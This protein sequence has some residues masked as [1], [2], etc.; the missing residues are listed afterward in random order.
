MCRVT[1]IGDDV[2]DGTEHKMA[3]LL[4][5]SAG[6]CFLLSGRRRRRRRR[7]TIKRDWP[8][9]G[10]RAEEKQDDDD[11]HR[12]EKCGCGPPQRYQG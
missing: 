5:M 4:P 1:Q 11:I 6:I 9:R 3:L 7:H 2:D 8:T 10:I 12:M